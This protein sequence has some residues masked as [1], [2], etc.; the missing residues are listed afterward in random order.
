MLLQVFS[1]MKSVAKFFRMS[2]D[3]PLS[4]DKKVSAPN[5]QPRAAITRRRFRRSEAAKTMKHDDLTIAYDD[6]ERN[7]ASAHKKK[8]EL[9]KQIN[10]S[11]LWRRRH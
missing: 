5:V 2:V 10:A 8:N 6:S 3:V 9:R 7:N 1:Q 11:T 4:R